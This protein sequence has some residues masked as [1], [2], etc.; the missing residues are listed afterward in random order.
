MKDKNISRRSFLKIFGAGTV[1]T[2]A[3]LVGCK[4]TDKAGKQA[5]SEYRNQV[6]PPVG[7]MTYRVNPKTKEKVSLLG[8][9]MMRLP[10]KVDKPDE[11]DQEMINKQIDYALEHGLN[12]IDTSPVYCQGK[13]EH[14]TGIALSRHKR[15]EYLVATKLSNFNHDY[16]SFEKSKEMYLNSM[17]ELQVD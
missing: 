14:C 16:W 9:G 6:E 7:K 15:S 2:T 1:A 8:Y 4:N 10:T 5:V 17:K 3:T 12:Y 13:S 11:F